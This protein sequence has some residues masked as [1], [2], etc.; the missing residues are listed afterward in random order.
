MSQQVIV[1]GAGIGGLAAAL[2]LARQGVGVRIIER[3]AEIREVG[4]GVQIG[5]N[6]FRA[7]ARLG[8]GDQMDAIG[9]RP[10]AIR[11]LDS[12]TGQELSRQ[13]LGDAFEARFQ[14]P[15]RVAFRADVQEVLLRE[16]QALPH[17]IE[18]TLGDGIAAFAQMGEAITAVLESGA[19][20]KG[21]GLIG[22]DGI[23]SR[24]RGQLLGEVDPRASGYVAYRALLPVAEMPEH[25]QTD[26]MQVW[27]GPLHHLVCYKV[28]RGELFNLVA[29]F[30][31]DRTDT[32]WDATGAQSELMAGFAG[33]TS[34]VRD[35]LM[36]IRDWKVWVLYD[37]DPEAG[38]S[39]GSVTLL[40]DAAH[41]ML[42]YLAQGACMAI[43][44]A[45]VL[46]D[47]VVMGPTLSEAFSAYEQ[48]RYPRTS[49]VQMAARR[50]GVINHAAGAEREARN[51]ALARQRSDDYEAV[52]WLFDGAGS[53]AGQPEGGYGV[54]STMRGSGSG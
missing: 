39:H 40:G 5:P 25:L 35:L 28:R 33:V 20:V 4:A 26:E 46:A 36:Q 2:A 48:A 29:I 42:P 21:A 7:F 17:M 34:S 13:T 37:R 30:R 22:A 11:L 52:A 8:V 15:Y 43:E 3:A 53:P 16:V 47:K 12:L 51:A 41:P 49:A 38:W 54:F 32:G 19:T 9:F 27:V 10:S 44:D 23:R 14:H 1:A 45:V 50:A 6:A 24:V 18:I 31:S